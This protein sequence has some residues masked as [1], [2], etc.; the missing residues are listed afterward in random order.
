MKLPL[1]RMWADQSVEWVE[2]APNGRMSTVVVL[3]ELNAF[4]DEAKL[5]TKVGRIEILAAIPPYFVIT[6]VGT[7]EID[8]ISKAWIPSLDVTPGL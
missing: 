3:P 1:E 7:M 4:V 5:F 6:Q 8:G 2:E